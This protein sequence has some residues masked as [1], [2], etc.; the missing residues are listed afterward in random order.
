MI[1]KITSATNEKIKKAV[2]LK[3]KKYRDNCGLFTGEGVRFSEMAISS[4]FEIVSVFFEPKILE[5]DRG[6]NLIESLEK[7]LKKNSIKL[8]ET[9]ERV[10][11]KLSNTKTPQ[12]VFLVI[13]QKNYSLKNI[14]N[15]KIF[16]ILDNVKDPGNAGTIIRLSDAIG[17]GAVMFTKNSVDAYSDKVIRATMGSIFNIPVL[18]NIDKTSIIDFAKSQNLKIYATKMN[19]PIC[20][21]QNLKD[22]GMFIFGSESEGV[23]A[24]FS[25]I[26]QNIS[27]P[28]VGQAESLNVASAVSALLYEV[29]RQQNY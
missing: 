25:N 4:D 16:V 3:E 19:A 15:S 29:Y 5:N 9:N 12:G 13:K 6:K 8:Y 11:Q 18:Q 17:V 28:I 20:Y 2:S 27:L 10:M 7:S 1:E 26:A 24:E 14:A 21:E 22:G 23:S